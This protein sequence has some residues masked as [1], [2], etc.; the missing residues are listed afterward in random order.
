[1]IAPEHALRPQRR[2]TRPH[3]QARA[4]DDDLP[5]LDDRAAVRRYAPAVDARAVPGAE[6]LDAHATVLE[7]CQ[8][9]V[10]RR[11]VLVVH[12]DL[13]AE[14]AADAAFAARARAALLQ[15]RVTVRPDLLDEHHGFHCRPPR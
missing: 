7:Q 3:V 14:I 10:P 2:M 5:L 13:A 4:P 9:R 6:V 12:H 8:P 11:G 1:E 15:D